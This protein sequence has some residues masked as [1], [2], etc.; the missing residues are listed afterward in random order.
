MMALHPLYKAIISP[1]NMKVQVGHYFIVQKRINQVS[2]QIADPF[3]HPDLR[4]ISLK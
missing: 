1:Y 2:L 3:G 4:V